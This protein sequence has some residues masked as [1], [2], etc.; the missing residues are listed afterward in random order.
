[1]WDSIYYAGNPPKLL[2]VPEKPLKE[3]RSLF[4]KFEL[5]LK[6]VSML[7]HAGL[8]EV[9]SNLT[10]SPKGLS[11]NQNQVQECYETSMRWPK[12]FFNYTPRFVRV[13]FNEFFQA[14]M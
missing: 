7:R 9:D 4:S 6:Q 1:M 13:H 12:K 2:R 14:A 11:V 10:T 8:I 5:L 3:A